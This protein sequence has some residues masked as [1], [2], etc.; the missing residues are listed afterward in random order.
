MEAI[1]RMVQFDEE[2]NT[3]LKLGKHFSKKDAKR[4]T[5]K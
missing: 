4:S 5:K 2:G 3:T 1:E